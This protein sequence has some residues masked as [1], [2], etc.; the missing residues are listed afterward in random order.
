M[1]NPYARFVTGADLLEQVA[2]TPA[3]LEA[4]VRAARD[5]DAPLAPGKWSVR[6][7]LAHLTDTEIAFGFRLRQ[8]VAET[9]HVIQP[10]DQ[11]KWAIGYERADAEMALALF[12]LLRKWNVQFLLG[13]AAEE[14]EKE[15]THPER[16]TMTVRTIVETM[17]GHDGNHLAQ[18]T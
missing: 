2:L 7:V 14:F 4:A 18:L 1:Q 8:A 9:G 17:A 5:I 3:K 11:E 13:L 6:Q 15:V 10:F 12:A 16:G